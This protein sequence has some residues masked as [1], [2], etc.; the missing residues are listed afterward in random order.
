MSLVFAIP[1]VTMR[2]LRIDWLHCADQGVTPVLLGDSSTCCC[3]TEAM[4]G[5]LIRGVS[6][7]GLR[8]RHSMLERP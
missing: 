4:A 5:M 6:S 3:E 2:S 1:S 7:F 8:S